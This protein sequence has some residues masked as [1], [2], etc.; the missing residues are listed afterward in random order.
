MLRNILRLSFIFSM[1]VL[2]VGIIAAHE[3]GDP[4]DPEGDGHIN[5]EDFH[6]EEPLTYYDDI[7]PIIEANCLACH[8]EGQIAAEYELYDPF[9]IRDS[10][11]YI[12]DLVN[13]RDM[14]PWMPGPQTTLELQNARI[15]EDEEIARILFWAQSGAQMGEQSDNPPNV[16][17]TGVPYALPQIRRDME[18]Y[19]EEPY[20]PGEANNDD[21]RCFIFDP[22]FTEP[23]YVTGYVFAPDVLTMA[24]HGIIYRMGEGARSRADNLNGQDGQQGWPCYNTTGLGGRFEE[25]L[26]T[27]TPGTF[28][29]QY[30][31]GTGYLVQPGEFFVMQMHYNTRI[32][33]LGDRS[34]FYIQTE[35]GEADIRSL[36][37]VQLM[38][39][40]EIPCPADAEGELCDRNAAIQYAAERYGSEFSQRPDAL[41]RDCNQTL[42]TYADQDAANATTFCETRIPWALDTVGVFGHMHELGKS[43]RIEINPGEEDNVVMLDIPRWDFHWQDRYQFVEPYT[44]TPGDTIRLTCTWDN[45]QSDDP[46]YIVWGEGTEDEMCFATIMVLEPE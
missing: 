40:V 5:I 32:D 11:D 18:F 38:A 10:A 14:P 28:P 23:T 19:L 46:R 4:D 45:T 21:Y 39:P 37:T 17:E 3:D 42:A 33:R 1:L 13:H 9:V 41:L 43:I 44:T 31:A 29:V 2:M 7:Q 16:F 15:L 25:M 20:M 35:P 6:F 36:F 30:P 22:G 8:A 12:A 26:G 34:G 27:W 24:H